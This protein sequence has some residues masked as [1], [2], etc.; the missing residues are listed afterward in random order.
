ML[1]Y[2]FL[3]LGV[4][5][6]NDNYLTANIDLIYMDPDRDFTQNYDLCQA[7]LLANWNKESL[8]TTNGSKLDIIKHF[9]LAMAIC[10]TVTVSQSSDQSSV[11]NGSVR[12]YYLAKIILQ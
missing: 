5:Y 2:V 10:N 9:M 8:L 12:I 1:N 11:P 7:I 3:Y 4:S 6:I